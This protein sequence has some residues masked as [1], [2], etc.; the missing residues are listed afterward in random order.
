M[1]IS[2]TA[3]IETGKDLGCERQSQGWSRISFDSIWITFFLDIWTFPLVEIPFR[4]GQWENNYSQSISRKYHTRSDTRMR[5]KSR[6][7]WFSRNETFFYRSHLVFRPHFR[8]TPTKSK[9]W[10]F[11]RNKCRCTECV[12]KRLK[13]NETKTGERTK[14]SEKNCVKIVFLFLDVIVTAV[15]LLS[16]A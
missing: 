5:A 12:A 16:C 10:A 3:E 6:L 14:E 15:T 4:D 13:M 8:R 2:A 7:R 9:M 11:T 1:C